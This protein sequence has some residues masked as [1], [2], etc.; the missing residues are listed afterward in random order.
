[1]P[2]VTITATPGLAP[3]QKKQLLERA[4]DA[5]AQSIGAPVASI[6]VM[7]TELADGDYLD[8]GRHGRS[9][10]MFL[11]ELIEGRTEELRAALIAALSRAAFEV[12]GIPESDVR[13][14]LI[15]FPSANM[16]MAG[17]ATARSLGR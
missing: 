9:T 13:V 6:R 1:M 5:V 3:A 16:G 11:V 2:Y 8:A 4:S 14:R 12:T 17:G 10:V 15:E 7:L